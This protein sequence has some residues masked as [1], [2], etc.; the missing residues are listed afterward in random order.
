MD[1]LGVESRPVVAGNLLRQPFAAEYRLRAYGEAAPVADH[2]H[3]C[4]LYVGNGHHVSLEMVDS[5]TAALR[6]ATT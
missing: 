6:T 2:I 1:G 5:L 3:E 4:G